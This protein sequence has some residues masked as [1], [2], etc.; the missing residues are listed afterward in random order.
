MLNSIRTILIAIF[1]AGLSGCGGRYIKD[2]F[3]D[4]I[5]FGKINIV[6]QYGNDITK[7]CQNT[8]KSIDDPERVNEDINNKYRYSNN[9]SNYSITSR[10]SESGFFMLKASVGK[11]SVLPIHCSQPI[12]FS[13][14]HYDG[15]D[16]NIASPLDVYIPYNNVAVYFGDIVIYLNQD[17]TYKIKSDGFKNQNLY[18]GS[19]SVIRSV[20][21][22]STQTQWTQHEVH[23]PKM[24]FP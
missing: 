8:V 7:Y 19:A 24:W 17:M 12:G 3:G 13:L 15:V 18:A 5:L 22:L 21:N 20:P 23:V 4:V 1:L 11:N 10:F 14:S 6:N 2:D 9:L 16:I